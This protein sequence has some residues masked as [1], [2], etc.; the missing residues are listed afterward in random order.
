[1]IRGNGLARMRVCGAA[2]LCGL[3]MVGC[4]T[5]QRGELDDQVPA[6]AN[7]QPPASAAGAATDVAPLTVGTVSKRIERLPCDTPV[8]AASPHAVA[9]PCLSTDLYT[10]LLHLSAR[11]QRR[12][13]AL[14]AKARQEMSEA[15]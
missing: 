12:A 5:A 8:V 1:M 7:G 3:V 11:H 6:P 10:K 15:H 4:Q 13:E 2:L 14:V 9:D